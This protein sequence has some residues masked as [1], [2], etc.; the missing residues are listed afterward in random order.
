[1]YCKNSI[2]N[3]F[4]I[5]SLSLILLALHSISIVV[6]FKNLKTGIMTYDIA[7][8]LLT[9]IFF[10]DISYLLYYNSLFGESVILSGFLM[11]FSILLSLLQNEK[12]SNFMLVLYFVSAIIFVGAKVANIP[13]GFII[14]LFSIYFFIDVKTTGKKILVIT[15]ICFLLATSVYFYKAIPEWMKKP[16][17]YHSVFFGILKN[18]D[19]PDK[20]LEKLGIDTKY[21]VL[22]NTNV[23]VNLKGFDIYSEE[24]QK[25]V[26][27]KAGPV[28]VS[29]YYLKNPGR[30]FEKLNL[31]A[32]ASLILRPPYLGNYQIED[33]T[34]IVKFAKRFSIWEWIRK[35]FTGY[36]FILVTSVFLLYF[37]VLFY[38]FCLYKKQRG[39][40][41]IGLITAKLMLMIF[42]GSQWIFPVIGNGEADLIKHMFLFNL[43]FDTMIII[44]V[45]DIIKLTTQ[46]LLNRKIVFSFICLFAVFFIIVFADKSISNNDQIVL[47][48][49]K[50]KPITWEVLEETSTHYFLVA[51]EIVDY[52]SFSLDN[53]YWIESDIR[54]WLNDDSKNGFLYEFSEHEKKRISSVPRITLLSPA[55]KYKKEYGSQP[56]YWFCIPGYAAQNYDDAYAVENIEKVFLMSVKEWESYDFKKRKGVPYWLRTPYSMDSTVRVVGEDGYVYHK[57]A[58]MKNIGVLPALILRK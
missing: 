54:V 31:S 33:H 22:A 29:L 35:Q 3:Y 25:E 23:Y 7:I 12:K 58:D 49:Y 48:K 13:L 2:I 14:A 40:L 57:K 24:F 42:A 17:N 56:H 19:N 26:Y 21:S 15:G 46:N 10:Y 28:E 55:Y 30:M 52:R 4:D 47:G 38:Q 45:V 27:D 11:W 36:A 8:L 9:V 50:G 18:S 53:N 39:N 32:E 20:D 34:E 6:L 43:L 1:M 51:K 5:I 44:L 16:N 41:L 37:A